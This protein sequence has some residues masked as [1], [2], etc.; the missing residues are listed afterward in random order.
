[1]N[2]DN[3]SKAAGIHQKIKRELKEFIDTKVETSLTINEI[4]TFIENRIKLYSDKNEL[5]NGIAF[6]VGLSLNNVAAHDT[7]I[8]NSTHTNY[9][10]ILQDSDVL[11][12]DYGVHVNGSIIDSAFT[13]TRNELYKPILQA[14]RESVDNI[15]KNI[16]VDMTISEIGDLSEEIVASY[17]TEQNGI[18]KPVKIIGNLCGHSILPWKIH[19]GKLIQNIKNNDKTKIEENDVLA[20]EV[21]TSNGSGTTILGRHNSHFM[22]QESKRKISRRS[23]ELNDLILE[24]FKTLPFTQRYLEKYTTLKYYDVCLDELYRTGYLS[25]H[26]P[27]LEADPTSIT[28]QFEET[29]LVSSN[30][31]LNLSGLI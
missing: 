1:M 10:H 17:E 4:C 29:I 31:I 23:Q 22:P 11:K 27:L 25:K 7:P 14:S 12:I 28:A 19:G 15:I 3:Y 5:N 9:N 24:K 26:P 2:S 21:F 8:P 20:I 16:G 6:P 13:W 18:F 30:K